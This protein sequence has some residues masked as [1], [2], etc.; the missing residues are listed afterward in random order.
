M[1]LLPL[2]WQEEFVGLYCQA[3]LQGT[4]NT[5]KILQVPSPL[6]ARKPQKKSATV[7]NDSE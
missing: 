5:M 7:I 6:G 1:I 4:E 3:L 2:F